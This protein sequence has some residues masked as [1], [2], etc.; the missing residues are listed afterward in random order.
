MSLEPRALRAPPD[1]QV[2]ASRVLPDP[3]DPLDPLALLDTPSLES[4]V[5]LADL[6]NP[7][8]P[9]PMVTREILEP[10]AP[11]DLVAC[12]APLEAQDLLACLPLASPA[13]LVCLEL[14]DQ[15][16]N[17]VTKD[18]PESLDCLARKVTGVLDLWELRARPDPWDHRDQ[19]EHLVC[20]A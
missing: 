8:F 11:R 7:E 13:L 16:E 1:P 3:Q 14:W 6:E 17:P 5:H 15:K 12:P 2:R 20:Q 9:E 18:T 10:L 19:L 4:P